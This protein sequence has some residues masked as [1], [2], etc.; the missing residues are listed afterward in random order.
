MVLIHSYLSLQHCLK[1]LF[2]KHGFNGLQNP[3]NLTLFLMFWEALHIALLTFST[4][5]V[6]WKERLVVWID[7]MCRRV[8]SQVWTLKSH[9]WLLKADCSDNLARLCPNKGQLLLEVLQGWL[10]RWWSHSAG[11]IAWILVWDMSCDWVMRGDLY[12]VL[13]TSLVCQVAWGKLFSFLVSSS[14]SGEWGWGF[15]VPLRSEGKYQYTN[16]SQ[17][18]FP[19]QEETCPGTLIDWWK[20]LQKVLGAVYST[21]LCCRSLSEL[22]VRLKPDSFK[23][24]MQ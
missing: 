20:V 6:E 2:R 7:V 14:V 22:Q 21:S 12:S 3:E 11:K 19:V 1:D 5:A 23:F 9:C 15:W 16:P 8:S 13:V 18:A 17:G 10:H 4:A 24:L